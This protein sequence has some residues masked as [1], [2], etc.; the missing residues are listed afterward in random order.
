MNEGTDTP[1]SSWRVAVWL[2]SSVSAF[3][4]TAAQAERLRRAL[5][6]TTVTVYD[7]EAAF[8]RGLAEVE[9]GIGWCFRQEWIDAAPALRWI[10]T[11]AAGRDYFQITPRP[12]MRVTYGAFQGALMA[13]TVAGMVLGESRG[14][15]EGARR[16]ATGDIWPR[17]TLAARLRCVRG[18]H[19]VIV[20][21]GRVGEWVGRL[22]KPFGVRV[23]GIQRQTPAESALSSRPSW[24]DAA[25]CLLPVSQLDAALTQADHVILVL[26]RTTETDHLM[27]A[28]RLALL[29]PGAVL[30][31]VGRGNAIDEDA[32]VRALCEGR[33]RGACL[34]VFAREPLPADSPLLHAPNLFLMP[35]VSAAAPEYLDLYIDEVAGLWRDSQKD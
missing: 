9:M 18:T 24:M 28:R 32:V 22:L 1:A 26:P 23:T 31:N 30:Y 7:D 33:L 2:H 25:D 20:G 4:L 29:P 11:P 10:S 21:F 6:G 8:A 19:A 35:H 16:Q 12:G 34:D 13:E 5:P 3:A 15:L 27:D 17:A 14:L